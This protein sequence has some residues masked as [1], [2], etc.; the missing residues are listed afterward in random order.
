VTD[1]GLLQLQDEF[2]AM[3]SHELRTPL[4]ALQGY[5]EMM[6]RRVD[7]RL[8]TEQIKTYA[9]NAL[10]QTKRLG[11]LVRDLT[12]VSRLRTGKLSYARELVDIV[13]LVQR[14]ATTAEPLMG[15]TQVRTDLQH[16]PLLVFGDRGRLE[17]VVLNLLTNAISY[18]PTAS[19]IDVGVKQDHDMVELSVHD[20]GPGIPEEHRSRIFSRFYHVAREDQYQ[21]GGLG[22]GLFIVRTIVTEHGG[23]V[24][25]NSVLG[26]GTTFTVHLPLADQSD[27]GTEHSEITT[28]APA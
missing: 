22:L 9:T 8:S 15:S 11:A 6:V 7:S 26:A 2:M 17:Q 27:S 23:T 20:T 10:S 19:Y 4:T 5:L 21:A 24:D 12:D 14:V 1:R 25:F 13:P 16:G 3:A 18:A 28:D